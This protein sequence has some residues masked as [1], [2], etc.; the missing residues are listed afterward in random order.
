MLNQT[1]FVVQ[2]V[3]LL[4]VEKHSPPIFLFFP[5]LFYLKK[6]ERAI[7][8]SVFPFTGV[9]ECNTKNSIFL[10]SRE[11]R[12]LQ[13]SIFVRLRHLK[14]FKLTSVTQRHG[15]LYEIQVNIAWSEEDQ[16]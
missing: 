13:G 16:E 15:K 4:N 6:G 5:T 2:F 1:E 3:K 8:I 11:K 14:Q 7:E 12:C 10:N 9:Y